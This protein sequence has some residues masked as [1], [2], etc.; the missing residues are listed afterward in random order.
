LTV[1]FIGI[2][3]NSGHPDSDCRESWASCV[4]AFFL[5]ASDR[6]IA[7]MEGPILFLIGLVLIY[8]ELFV[9]PVFG[10]TGVLGIL[11]V[12]SSIVVTMLNI[13]SPSPLV[14]VVSL[15]TC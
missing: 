6:R 8:L 15:T 1:A 14:H 2:L 4:D 7:G 11:F 10:L 3:P 5:G 12:V 9:I 13:P